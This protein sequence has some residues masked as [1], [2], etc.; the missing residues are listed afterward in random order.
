MRIK[1]INKPAKKKDSRMFSEQEKK[2][3]IKCG[4]GKHY[5]SYAGGECICRYCGKFL[6]PSGKI[7]NK[8]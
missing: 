1:K 6:Q 7:T 5:W 2:G 4:N 8:P 3:K